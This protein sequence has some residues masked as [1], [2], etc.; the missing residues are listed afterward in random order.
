MAPHRAKSSRRSARSPR[1]SV[2]LFPAS[3]TYGKWGRRV[4]WSEEEDEALRAGV[5]AFGIGNWQKV[6]D[7]FV[8]S[9]SYIQCERRWKYVLD[10][11][12]DKSP[13]T[14]EEDRL[15]VQGYKEHGPCWTMIAN[16][17]LQGRTALKV[18][19]RAT[20]KLSCFIANG[21]DADEEFDSKSSSE[22]AEAE[23]TT[24]ESDNANGPPGNTNLYATHTEKQGR[25]SGSSADVPVIGND[26]QTGDDGSSAFNA[27]ALGGPP[28][29]LAVVSA[30]DAFDGW[31]RQQSQQSPGSALPVD[32]D[33]Q[34]H[35]QSL[36]A[37]IG[38]NLAPELPQANPNWPWDVGSNIGPGPSCSQSTWNPV[39]SWG[40]WNNLSTADT[41]ISGRN[42]STIPAPQDSVFR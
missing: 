22:E 7:N 4:A 17:L 40:V 42:L 23:A 30:L 19:Q 34:S 39:E 8:T 6:A 12:I 27:E 3:T 29:D 25:P 32:K 41:H 20:Y 24:N 15:L 37:F 1:S 5:E 33:G 14:E 31:L 13:W 38:Q 2:K 36:P 28:V 35:N 21:C 11:S 18:R 9:R 26:V 16:T 10:P